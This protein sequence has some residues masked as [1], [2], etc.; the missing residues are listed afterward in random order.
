[1][2]RRRPSVQPLL[3]RRVERVRA[4]GPDRAAVPQVLVGHGRKL[5]DKNRRS[6]ERNSSHGPRRRGSCSA[7]AGMARP[8]RVAV[9]DPT[10]DI[11]DILD[12][13]TL[14]G[15]IRNVADVLDEYFSR[16]PR[17]RA[18]RR[19]TGTGLATAP[20]S[21]GSATCSSISAST[22]AELL[23]QCLRRAAAGLITLDPIGRCEGT[24]RAAMGLRANADV[25]PWAARGDCPRG[26]RRA[27]HASGSLTEE[28]VEKDYVLGWLLW[29]IGT[30]PVLSDAWVFKGGTCLKKC[31]I[32]TYRFSEDLDFTVL[33]GGPSDP[34]TSSPCSPRM[35]ARDHG[36]IRHRLL[37]AHH[38]FGCAQ[39]RPRPKEGPSTPRTASQPR[40]RHASSSTSAADELVVR[41]PVLRRIAI[42]TRTRSRSGHGSRATRSRKSSP[43][44]S[45]PWANEVGRATSTT[46][47]TCSAAT[48]SA[49]TRTRS[50][51]HWKRNAP[52]RTSP[53]RRRQTS[54]NRRCSQ[55]W[56]RNGPTC[57]ATNFPRCRHSAPFLD[58]LPL[59]FAWLEGDAE[60]TEAALIPFGRDE[61]ASWSPPPTVA[62]WGAGVPLETVRFAAANHLLVEL[63]YDGRTRLIE[64]Y[65][66]R[67]SARWLPHPPR[68]ASRR[69]RPPLLPRRPH[70]RPSRHHNAIPSSLP[71]RVLHLGPLHAPLQSRASS[72]RRAARVNPSRGPAGLG[73][74]RSTSTSASSAAGSSL[75]TRSRLTGL[76]SAQRPVRR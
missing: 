65:S 13:P 46:S 50:D 3:H 4:L 63:D 12:D 76:Q 72:G 7:R 33:P 43:R 69:Q 17:R 9:S 20:S 62:T 2:G 15:G 70:R 30:D 55:S 42:P 51:P 75:H 57:S 38:G 26:H 19:H 27:G 23:A 71:D 36:R 34:R 14:G 48:T 29:G 1:M 40:S 31:Y 45:E 41:A 21:S 52:Q 5:G 25:R 24:D 6:R 22:R 73:S 59:L 37:D 49:C 18:A 58:E 35:L 67:R 74:Y 16:A 44:R 66:L 8:S 53:F 32:E 39:R 54:T 61:D 47:S 68:R 10:R 28:V 11:I 64:P 56:S 60:E